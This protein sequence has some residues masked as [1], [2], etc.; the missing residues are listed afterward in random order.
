MSV[1]LLCNTTIRNTIICRHWGMHGLLPLPKI[2]PRRAAI[3][4][5]F[6]RYSVCVQ[7]RLDFRALQDSLVDQDS[8]DQEDLR[9]KGDYQEG[10]VEL[11]LPED[12]ASPDRLALLV[13]QAFPEL[14][15]SKT[16]SIYTVS[17]KRIC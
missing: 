1:W 14:Q 3:G 2:C 4:V 12:L 17:S 9:A 16:K 8:L 11:A 5:I 7:E 6:C 15:A 10:W 13:P